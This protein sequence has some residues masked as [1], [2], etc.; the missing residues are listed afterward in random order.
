MKKALSL[1][2][3]FLTCGF[4]L[5]GAEPVTVDQIIALAKK[6]PR[7]AALVIEYAAEDNPKLLLE[8]VAAAVRELP[9]Q[10]AAIVGGL[11]KAVPKQQSAQPTPQQL[12]RQTEVQQEILRTAIQA[13]PESAAEITAFALALFPA[14]TAEFIQAASSAV[15]PAQRAEIAG[16][17][18]KVAR[19]DTTAPDSAPTPQPPP[20]GVFPAQPIRP[21]L[22]SPSG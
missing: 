11:I 20:A 3:V 7:N 21:D 22:I 1:A 17:A 9:E 10:A 15:P 19:F 18:D 14:K 8:L 16:L 5:R 6:D 2:L 12:A 13:R 4:A